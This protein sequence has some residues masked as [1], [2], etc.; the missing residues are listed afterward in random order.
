[1]LLKHPAT[2]HGSFGGSNKG[3]VDN[4]IRG[5]PTTF[6]PSKTD[7]RKKSL[8]STNSFNLVCTHIQS[9]PATRPDYYF[10]FNTIKK[11]ILN[12]GSSVF[13]PKVSSNGG[14]KSESPS[15]PFSL[16]KNR[17]KSPQID[18]WVEMWITSIGN[19]YFPFRPVWL[20]SM[21]MVFQFWDAPSVIICTVSHNE[22]LPSKRRVKQM[23]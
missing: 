9:L 17:S 21:N 23:G 1:M 16:E 13:I 8:K 6:A 2:S 19:M 14:N 20:F 22:A 12:A 5:F 10:L 3:D 15:Q 18:L 7:K 4:S 11:L